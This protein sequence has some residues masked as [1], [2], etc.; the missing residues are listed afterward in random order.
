MVQPLQDGAAGAFPRSSVQLN[1]MD[2]W[3]V[4]FVVVGLL[5]NH[6]PH[7]GRPGSNQ[8]FSLYERPP[9]I[10]SALSASRHKGV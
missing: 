1:S 3:K 2:V 8:V 7:R 5:D 4:S 6:I 10:F 9:E